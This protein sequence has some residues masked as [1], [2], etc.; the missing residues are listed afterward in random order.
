MNKVFEYMMLGLPIVQFNLRQATRDAA[1]AALVVSGA[2]AR[3]RSRTEFSRLWMI[4]SGAWRCQLWDE[5][6]PS[7]KFQ[8]T[9]EARRYLTA[10]R[11]VF[12]RRLDVN[13]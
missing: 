8:W 7:V 10:Y 11:T 13:R 1:E 2:F 5:R 3:R 9:N 6:S 12:R 4:R